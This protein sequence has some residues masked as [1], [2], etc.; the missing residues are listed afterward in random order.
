MLYTILLCLSVGQFSLMDKLDPKLSWY[1]LESK[2]FAV[3]FSNQ[4]SLQAQE[5]LAREIVNDCEDAYSKLTSFMEWRP[6]QRTN[7]VIADIYD[8]SSGW[9]TP[10]PNN[11]IFICP[12]FQTKMLVNYNDWFEHLIIHEYTHILNM[13]MT[14]G[15]PGFFRKLFGK[16]ITPNAVMPLSFNEGLSV[17]NETHFTG[18]GRSRSSYHRMMMR[19]AVLDNK[20]FPIDKWVTYELAQFPRGE[21]PYF[22]GSMFDEYLADKY[23]TSKL[24]QYENWYSGG[25][26]LFYNTQA[27]RVYGKSFCSLWRD[28]KNAMTNQYQTEIAKIKEN[29]VTQTTQLAFEGVYTESPLFSI[30]GSEIYYVSHNSDEYPAIKICSVGVY[31]RQS[32]SRGR[33]S[34][35]RTCQKPH[36]ILRKPI[37]SAI[38]LSQDG[39]KL[40]FSIQDVYNNFYN[41]DD[42]YIYDILEKNLSRITK[43]LRATDPDFSPTENKIVFV[44]NEL[45]QTNLCIMDLDSNKITQLTNSD[46]YTQYLQPRFSNDGKKI[47]AAVWK[48]GGEQDIYIFDL[49]TDWILPV[50][51]DKA[52]DIQPCWTK[53]DQYL[54]F[55]SDRSNVFNIY[56][57]NLKSHK[58]YQITNVLTGAFEPALSPDNKKLA[59]LQYSSKGYDVH[60]MDFKIDTTV[61]FM[62]TSD[63]EVRDPELDSGQV[64]NTEDYIK[65]DSI[66]PKLYNYNP[67]PAI[68]PKFWLPLVSYDN[69]W[70]IGGITYGADALFQH[71]YLIQ[72]LYD[73][74]DKK[75]SVYANYTLDR[76]YPTIDI[77]GYYDK[78]KIR[79]IL[80][81]TVTFRKAERYQDL[82]LAYLIN[83]DNYLLSGLG[84]SH[85]FSNAK[86][87]PYSISPEQGTSV[88][89]TFYNYEKFLFSR[90]NLTKIYINA[91]E[92]LNLPFKH[93]ILY[94]NFRT[95]LAFGDSIKKY[96]YSLGGINEQ[97][98]VRGYTGNVIK[99]QHILTLV[100]EYRFPLFW[101]ERGFGIMPIFFKNFSG[102]IFFDYGKPLTATRSS[103]SAIMGTGAEISLN[104]LLFYEIPTTLTFGIASD[105][106]TISKPQLYFQF[107]PKIPFL[108]D[109]KIFKE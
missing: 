2:H 70:S 100:A 22:Y 84:F 49:V 99:A 52:L 64:S 16:I 105:L 85:G 35:L 103:S 97:F 74:K 102:K 14:Y 6:K 79:G 77:S 23:G 9:A 15:I 11:L 39:T 25:I 1:T 58:L 29:P 37:S 20:I 46:D 45:G 88:R 28:F 48:T 44:K 80:T 41:Y 33:A 24:T 87:Y 19:S 93:H 51:Q 101:I 55:S 30:D 47:S 42:I 62:T 98:S 106:K 78:G 76:F 60:M 31:P 32:N 90:Y 36:T 27:K 54:L 73:L 38:R 109:S 65:T 61:V 108:S 34:A 95:G 86:I 91:N 57:Y 59:F 3:H 56:A 83:K 67:F 12:T 50:T 8:Y 89:L 82:S 5:K 63:S 21:T 96:E 17:F 53:D 107:S 81:S 18:F 4:D 69:S 68:L 72:G 13:D 75:P 10:F 66:E 71:K 40:I 7:I 94:F 104:T 92:Y 26:P 43:G